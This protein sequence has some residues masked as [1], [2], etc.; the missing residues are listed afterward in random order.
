MDENK[1]TV[2]LMQGKIVR[3]EL[4]AGTS[5]LATV[6]DTATKRGFLVGTERASD[7]DGSYTRRPVA[8]NVIT[9]ARIEEGWP[10]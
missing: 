1:V 3:L 5:T 9:I 2:T 8:L 7:R 6:A 10:R 4:P